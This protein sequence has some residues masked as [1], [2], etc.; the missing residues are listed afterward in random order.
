VITFVNKLVLSEWEFPYSNTLTFAQILVSILILKILDIMGLIVLPRLSFGVLKTV[1]PLSLFY[2]LM[3][4]TGLAALTWMNVPMF[5]TLRRMT[6]LIVLIFDVGLN[7]IKVSRAEAAAIFVMTLGAIVAGAADLAFDLRGYVLI[8]LNCV[9]TAVYLVY[10]K[11][12]GRITG[13]ESLGLMYINNILSIPVLLFV[14]VVSGE[15]ET[16]FAYEYWFYPTFLIL[17]IAS[18]VAALTLNYTI[19]LCTEYNSAVVTSVTGQLKGLLSTLFG[20]IF[21]SGYV[22]SHL[23]ML[24]LV[25]SSLGSVL[26]TLVKLPMSAQQAMLSFFGLSFLNGRSRKPSVQEV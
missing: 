20:A 26:Y 22:Y 15:S 2:S 5:G 23:N 4:V 24:G 14:F 9:L 21:L 17:F 10:I 7:G 3:I 6:T 25:I 19:F 8:A 12:V 11:Y 1:L 13:L 16:V 18:A